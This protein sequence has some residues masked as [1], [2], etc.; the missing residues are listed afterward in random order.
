MR[1]EEQG[2]LAAWIWAQP[3]TAEPLGLR[4]LGPHPQR[5]LQ[6][7]REHAKALAL[8]A[9]ASAYPHVQQWLGEADFAGMAWAFARAHPPR[10]G[11]MNRWGAELARFLEA[12]PGME[13][14]PPLLAAF[15]WQLHCLVGAADDPPPDAALW[16]RLKEEDS[17]QLRLLCSPLLQVWQ[18][19]P[20]L[21]P[22]LQ[23]GAET[24]LDSLA[25]GENWL[26]WRQG[27]RPCWAA[28]TPGLATLVRES[29][30]RRSLAAAL[31][32]ALQAEPGFDLGLAL[33]LGW[34]QGWWL[35]TAL[36]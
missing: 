30:A 11:D 24:L 21:A 17:Q 14:E 28:V 9:L 34:R 32:A 18:L 6:A 15:D 10:L 1:A 25:A 12:V 2:A 23:A 33:H 7:Y 26:L 3:G 36:L 35:D 29:L 19:P 8:R 22:L 4:G 20:T 13:A 16:T 31:E 5:A 27:W